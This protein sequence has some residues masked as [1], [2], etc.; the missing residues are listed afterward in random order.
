MLNICVDHLFCSYFTFVFDHTKHK[1]KFIHEQKPAPYINIS[2]SFIALVTPSSCPHFSLPSFRL[3]LSGPLKSLPYPFIYVHSP[4]LLRSMQD[5]KSSIPF[6][7]NHCAKALIRVARLLPTGRNVVIGTAM[8]SAV[9]VGPS[10]LRKP[11]QWAWRQYF[12]CRSC[13]WGLCCQG[14]DFC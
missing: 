6:F 5:F 9:A 2:L 4:L 1:D 11:T 3:F 10:I 8:N 7:L 14:H 13:N 12:R